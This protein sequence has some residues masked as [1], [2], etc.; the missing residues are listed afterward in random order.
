MIP[1]ITRQQKWQFWI[2]RGGTFTDIIALSP[3]N[4]VLTAKYLSENP[5]FYDD[6]ALYAIEQFLADSDTPS[7]A[8]IRMGTTV[9]TNAL[10]ERKGSPTALLIT[11]GFKDCLVIGYQ[12]RPDIFALQITRPQPLYAC[13]MEIKERVDAQGQILEPLD[14]TDT[15][16]KLQ[17]LF[18]QGIRSLAVVLMHAWTYPEHELQIAHWAKQIG[19]TQIS[20]SHQVSPFMKI[21]RR[22]D[23]TVLDAYLSPVLRRYVD[24]FHQGVKKQG[25]SAQILFMQSTGGLTEG[26]RFQGKDCILSG[27]AGGIIGA[28]DIARQTGFDKIIAFDMGGTSTDVAHYAGEL[29]RTTETEIAGIRLQTPMLN[30]H[31][32]AAGGGSILQFDG[33]RCRV[34]PESAGANP[35]PACYRKGG[36]LTVTDANV[37]LGKLPS[38]PA[39]FGKQGNESLDR[40]RV[41][42]L[43]TQITEQINSPN[44][45]SKTVFEIAEGFIDIAVENMALAIKRISVQKGYDVSRYALCCYGAAGGQHACKVADRLGIK[46]IILHPLAGVLS[47]YGM[48]VARIRVLKEQAVEQVWSDLQDGDLQI[49]A[50]QLYQVALTELQA[51]QLE[52]QKVSA[53]TQIRIRYAGTDTALDIALATQTEMANA[54]H[55][56]YQQQFGFCYT[57]KPLICESLSV[58]LIAETSR[59][60]ATVKTQNITETPPDRHTDLFS[61]GQFWQAPVLQRRQLTAQQVVNGPAII[62]EPTSTLVI[63]PGWQATLNA[64]QTLV[65]TRHQAL[66]AHTIE[67]SNRPDP[68]LLEIFNRQFMSIAEQMG[69]VLQKTSHSVNIKERL[70]FSCAVF[71]AKGRLIANAPHIPVHLGSMGESVTALIQAPQIHLAPDE[72]YLINSPFSGGTHLPDIT[73]IMPV[74]AEQNNT[75]L[76]FLAA[77]GHHADVGG[78][79]PGS[80]PSDSHHIDQEG[81]LNDGMV[82]VKQGQFQHQAVMQWLQSS[83]HPARNPAQNIAD[84]QAQVAACHKGKTELFK[85]IEDYSLST[86]MRYMGFVRQHAAECVRRCLNE[87][88]S[89]HF[90]NVMDNGAQIRIRVDIHSATREAIVDFTGTS[91][92]QNNNF[93]APAAVCKA[94]VMY[95]FRMLVADDIPLNSGCMEPVKIIL[96]EGCF[97][98]P[99][100]PAAVVAGNVETSQQIVDTLLAALGQLAASQGTMNNL[101]F[102]NERVQYYETLCGGSGAGNGINGCDAVQT[103]MTNSRITDPEVLEWRLPV[104]LEE[105]SIRAGSGGK[106][107]WSGGCGIVRRIQFLKDLTVSI[108]SGRRLTPPLGLQGGQAGQ[109][110]INRLIRADGESKLLPSCATLQVNKGDKLEI[111]TPGGGGFGTN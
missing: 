10:L 2:D 34:G 16:T 35:G 12:N 72:V 30:I 87:L 65:L 86:V 92:Q 69:F 14:Q 94:A 103:H 1:T 15:Q 48:G 24:Q 25:S 50:D 80:M 4:Q 63:E 90:V 33:L 54:F 39:V 62:L 17:Q 43:F 55:D 102:G 60:P 89:G 8:S 95:V 3:Q 7:I 96:P 13:R 108:L 97:L 36:P 67:T 104:R 93:N 45:E 9:G 28:V 71:D 51:Q 111:L 78:A 109:M 59:P 81:V 52:D 82:I 73:V 58:E 11:T 38:F 19:F 74:F 110:G 46:T 88:K 85:L 20:L 106:G 64:D 21:V 5:E 27:P 18:D 66:A 22:G 61:G 57:D 70:D 49:R 91:T 99:S 101:S 77:R 29:E 105:F 26:E 107:R 44:N 41:E 100:Y 75:P 53:I 98:N 6:A 83:S 32:V 56:Q 40:E 37:L 31:T 47:A 76:F 79:T 84:L 68:I 23:T 42:V